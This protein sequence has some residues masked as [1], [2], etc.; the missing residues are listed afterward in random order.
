MNP[1]LRPTTD[2]KNVWRVGVLTFTALS[3]E[4]ETGCFLLR[5]S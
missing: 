4:G 1:S 3:E 5:A 2:G